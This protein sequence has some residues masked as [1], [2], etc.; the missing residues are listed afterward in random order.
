MSAE[1]ILSFE[2]YI[3]LTSTTILVFKKKL[4]ILSKIFAHILT[5]HLAG[6]CILN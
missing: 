1:V 4:N 2:T 3:K 5:Y 6:T